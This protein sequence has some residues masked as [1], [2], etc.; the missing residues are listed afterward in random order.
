MSRSEE[1]RGVGGEENEQ[2]TFS[3]A[4]RDSHSPP[5]SATLMGYGKS[6][7]SSFFLFLYMGRWGVS[8]KLSL[9]ETE[10]VEVYG[11][12]LEVSR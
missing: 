9:G 6:A 10:R 2:K 3:S 5:L 4:A 7:L 12:I 11:Q 1:V 8:K